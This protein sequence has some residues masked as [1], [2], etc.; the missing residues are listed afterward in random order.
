MSFKIIGANLSPFVRKTRA[1][2]AEK[3]IDYE[4]EPLL[5]FGV[6]DEYKA[7]SPL[8]KI[9]CLE[10]DGRA[11]PDSSVICAYVERL[12]AQPALY[13]SDP[14]DFAQAL[15]FE[16]YADGAIVAA[17]IPIFQGRVIARLLGKEADE[18]QAKKGE[19]GIQPFCD[20][21]EARLADDREYLVGPALTIADIATASPFVNF[22]HGGWEP[23][24]GRWPKLSAYL[25]RIYSRPSFKALIEEEKAGLPA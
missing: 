18:A 16:E 4:L 10:H 12:Q 8:G 21:L 15:W 5:P 22:A 20:Y 13:P 24:A 17:G 1:F 19:E 25:G 2:F 7:K 3:G 23:D 14:W 9:P 6:S 11:L